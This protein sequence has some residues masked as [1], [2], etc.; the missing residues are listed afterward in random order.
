MAEKSNKQCESG[1]ADVTITY[2]EL[3]EAKH[4]ALGEL[5]ERLLRKPP[6][7]LEDYNEWIDE[8]S[9]EELQAWLADEDFRAWLEFWDKPRFKRLKEKA[10]I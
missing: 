10:N 1:L 2:S 7:E 3:D 8:L 6:Y 5:W 4:R 9:A